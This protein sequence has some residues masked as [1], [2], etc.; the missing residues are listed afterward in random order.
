MVNEPSV[1]ELLRFYCNTYTKN[2]MKI[3][4]YR[5][6]TD[7]GGGGG[8]FPRGR[9]EQISHG[10]FF[11][12]L[13]AD[14]TREEGHFSRGWGQ[15]DFLRG[16]ISAG[17]FGGGADFWGLGA[18]FL[19]PAKHINLDNNGFLLLWHQTSIEFSYLF[20]HNGLKMV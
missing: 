4:K 9:G 6:N 18:G 17:R 7:G 2:D 11:F 20:H 10:A 19:I 13:G 14:F 5:K 16:Q 1:F 12:F 8:T 3:F 15:G